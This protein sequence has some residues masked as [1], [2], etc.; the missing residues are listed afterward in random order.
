MLWAVTSI[1]LVKLVPFLGF[2]K[3][4]RLLYIEQKG[5]P[6]SFTFEYDLCFRLTHNL[7]T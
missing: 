2:K 4:I 3:R 5:I 6:F 1:I 7:D